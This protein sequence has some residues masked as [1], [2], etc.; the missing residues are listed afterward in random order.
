MFHVKSGFGAGVG[1]VAAAVLA[2]GPAAA[3]GGWTVVSVP[4]AGQRAILSSVSAASG[5]SAWAVGHTVNSGGY[6]GPLADHWNGTSWQ[7]T[8]VPNNGSSINKIS[9]SAVSAATA[10]DAWTVGISYTQQQYQHPLAYHWD[11]RAWTQISTNTDGASFSGQLGVADIGTGNAW[12]VGYGLE[13]W[14]GTSWT[15]LAYPDPENPG[16]L[17][18]NALVEYGSLTAISADAAND[19]W[20][21]GFYNDPNQ[22][23][24]QCRGPEETFSLHWNGTSWDEVPMPPVD[25]STYLEYKVN[26]IDAISPS[27]VWAVG[28]TSDLHNVDSTLIEH[29]NGTS[30][31][32]MPA[33]PAAPAALTGVTSSSSGGVWAVGGSAI[34][35]WNGTS[36]TTVSGADPSSSSVLYGVSTRPGAS[37]TWAVGANFV[38]GS[39]FSPFVLKNG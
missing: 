9:L 33:P 23:N 36:W 20:V 29:W 1:A 4:P 27:D 16:A 30:W 28:Y 10:T 38:S 39:G 19:I 14:N 12:A 22:C 31:S 26:S 25:N 32:V 15:Q 5:T 17:T 6:P 11:G 18:T 24:S 34:L 8:T 21:V 7:Q 2:A 13:H 3:A 35:F 37:L